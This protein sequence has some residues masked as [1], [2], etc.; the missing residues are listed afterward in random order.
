MPDI[1]DFG[2]RMRSKSVPRPLVKLSGISQNQKIAK[3]FW[4]QD[5]DGL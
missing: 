5:A 3:P 2:L 4:L 1:I